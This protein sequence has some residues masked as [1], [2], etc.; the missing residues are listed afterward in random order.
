MSIDFGAFSQCVASL[1]VDLIDLNN[2]EELEDAAYVSAANLCQNSKVDVI[3][4]V[5]MLNR[6][7][8]GH[9]NNEFA[10]L[11]TKSTNVD[12]LYDE[13]TEESMAVVIKTLL[14]GIAFYSSKK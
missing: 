10:L 11:L 5:D 9:D 6:A 3:G 12:W 1:N 13:D 14:D 4:L 2:R 8:D 7:L